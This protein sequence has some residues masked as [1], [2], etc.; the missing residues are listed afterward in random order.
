M[1]LYGSLAW[2]APQ[3][4]MDGYMTGNYLNN[5]GCLFAGG[6]PE[7]QRNILATAGLGLPRG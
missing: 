7:I 5:L 6:T 3:A 1:G 4:P 2:H